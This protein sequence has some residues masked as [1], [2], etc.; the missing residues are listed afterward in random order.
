MDDRE[1]F[2]RAID[3]I[4]EDVLSAKYGAVSER[5]K[6]RARGTVRPAGSGFDRTI[7]LHG[8]TRR[9]ALAQVKSL[10]RAVAGSRK[11]IL[12]ITGRGNNSDGNIAVIR[13]AVCRYLSGEG[14]GRI[15]DFCFAAQKDGG[16]GA[17]EI[18]TR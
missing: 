2:L 12:V 6:R 8:L 7:D 14:K 17:I 13:D 18:V 3:D 10:I 15:E 1:R 9:E 11:R 16:D 5:P 4:P